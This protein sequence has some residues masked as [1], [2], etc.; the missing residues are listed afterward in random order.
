[1]LLGIDAA[2]ALVLLPL[3]S[4]GSGAQTAVTVL[5]GL[6]MAATAVV[7]IVWF[8]RIRH[9]AGVW[10]A[11]RRSRGWAIGAWFTPGVNLW[12]PYEIAA[13]AADQ[14]EAGPGGAGTL[15]LVRAWWA[16][17]ILAW[18]TGFHHYRT[19]GFLPDG[20]TRTVSAF[21]ISLGGTT[22]SC[23]VTAIAAVLALIMVRRLSAL[24]EAR[25]AAMP[26]ATP[27]PAPPSWTSGG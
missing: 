9:N 7:F 22:V 5:A 4:T 21:N 25:I 24:Q 14:H 13:D 18:V 11:Q 23:A 17:W 3:R 8:S 6:V 16:A 26:V 20:S 1:V 15:R 19:V 2:A 27:M 10:G 12:F